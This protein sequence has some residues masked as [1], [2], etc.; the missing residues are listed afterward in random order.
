MWGKRGIAESLRTFS[1]H[2]G[3]GFNWHVWSDAESLDDG[4]LL[5]DGRKAVWLQE[6]GLLTAAAVVNDSMM[7]WTWRAVPAS[8]YRLN[9]I[10]LTEMTLEYF[11]MADEIVI[12]RAGAPYQH[13]IET[14]RFAGKPG[15]TSP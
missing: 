1:P 11:R 14:R 4:A 8:P 13:A 7:A 5:S 6:N 2:R 3:N 10:A 9:L 15:V 12:P